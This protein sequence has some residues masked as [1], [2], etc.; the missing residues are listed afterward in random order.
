MNDVIVVGLGPAGA[1]A[2]LRLA[3]MGYKVVAL[4][5]ESFP[6]SKSCGG[7]VSAKIDAIKDFD[8]SH[9]V[10]STVTGAIFSLKGSKS[11]DI[12]SDNVVGYNISRTVFDALLVEK[13]REAGATILEGRR[14]KDFIA[15]S[16]SVTVIT[17]T[18]EAFKGKF[19]VCADG[20]AGGVARQ[21]FGFDPT[22]GAVALT[23]EVP[24]DAS[25]IEE[26]KGKLFIDLGSVPHGYAWVFPKKKHLS[27]GVAG[28]IRR[29]TGRKLRDTFEAFTRDHS[30]LKDFV[31]DES[32][33][34]TLPFFYKGMPSVT[35]GRVLAVGDAGHLVDPFL[36]EGI[37]FAIRSAQIAAEAIDGCLSKKTN[38]LAHYSDWVRGD[39]A[40]D[41]LALEKLGKLIYS[42]PRLWFA[43]VE[44]NPDIM[45][46]YF[47]VIRGEL[48]AE[49]F[50]KWVFS[51]VKKKPWKLI[52]GLLSGS[53]D[54]QA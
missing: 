25:L 46:R 54:K 53:R 15:T 22:H 52:R 13:A 47:D 34:C 18:G 8:F 16:G 4:D 7:C 28:D 11:I 31:I 6:R 27:V 2:A 48:R 5:K 1:T 45:L 39:I 41:F 42:Y 20:S 12:R 51:K 30:V 29:M 49:E 19:L 43:M 3:S 9:I 44:R 38:T 26:L 10:E 50:Y 14:V 40:R 24:C 33:G 32:I 36:G 21:Y 35:K 37:Y 17:D 23:A